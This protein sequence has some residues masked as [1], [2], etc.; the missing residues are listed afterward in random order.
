[1]TGVVKYFSDAKGFGFLVSTDGVQYFV[2]HSDI[3]QAEGRRTLVERARVE[4]DAAPGHNGGRS[5]VALN[6]RV[7]GIDHAVRA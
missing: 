2:H 6:V 5:P 3:V 1:M 7:T 4:F